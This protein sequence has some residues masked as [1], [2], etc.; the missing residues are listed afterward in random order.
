MFHTHCGPAC[1]FRSLV[2]R[3]VLFFSED[4]FHSSG[5]AA[6]RGGSGPPVGSR[7]R[8]LWQAGSAA[9]L[10]CMDELKSL[11]VHRAD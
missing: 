1:C 11:E 7:L 10:Y 2:L 6:G 3:L 4:T 5:G 8:L 9:D